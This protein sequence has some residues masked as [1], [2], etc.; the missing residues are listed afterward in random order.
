MEQSNR[1]VGEPEVDVASLPLY[2][3][4]KTKGSEF[5]PPEFL[6]LP[7]AQHELRRVRLWDGDWAWLVTRYNDVRKLAAD[8]RASHD[9]RNPRFPFESAG[10]RERAVQGQSFTNMDDPE[11]RRLRSMVTRQF[12]ARQVELRRPQIQQMV[13]ELIDSMLAKPKPVDLVAEFAL[14]LPSNLICL[15]L[16]V[17]YEDQAFFQEVSAIMFRQSTPPDVTRKVQ[18]ELLDYLERLVESK[19]ENPQDDLL[20]DLATNHVASE[21]LS[22][23]DA[24]ITARLLLVA[25]HET[26]AN[27]ISLGVLALLRNPDQAA[28]LR[29]TGDPS[30]V[31]GA[32]DELLRY[33]TIVQVSNRRVAL[34]D[35]ELE[36]GTI[37]AGERI[38]LAVDAANRNAEI[39]A[40]P[41][42]L[43]IHRDARRHLGLGFGIHQCLGQTLA[44]VELQVAYPS[45]L[46]RLPNLRLAGDPD[47]IDWKLDGM[48]YGLHSLPLTWD[49]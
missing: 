40:D 49:D 14:P 38:L 48:V 28:E 47:D 16:G 33:L 20:S 27:Q 42:R 23:A 32:V 31:A 12:T 2:P 18:G 39:F 41:H 29:D 11:H 26:T 7:E 1:V 3:M 8:Q 5:D 25:G 17:P 30:L 43:D 13:D 34:E 45:L 36:S 22:V 9:T 6:T 24:A 37:R 15:I 19:I 21:E 10:F 46:R 44:R 4:A 35:I